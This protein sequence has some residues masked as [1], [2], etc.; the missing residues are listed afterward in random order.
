MNIRQ[1]DAAR[2]VQALELPGM[3]AVIVL[4]ENSVDARRN[5]GGGGGEDGE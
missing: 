5:G 1:A 4:R 3:M 2:L